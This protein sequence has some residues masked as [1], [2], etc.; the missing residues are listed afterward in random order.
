DAPA[1]TQEELDKQLIPLYW[2]R[3]P[4]TLP[5]TAGMHRWVWDLH[6][7][8]PT[9]THYEYPIS[10]VPHETPRTPQGALALPGTYMVRLK[11]NGKVL[12]TSLTLKMDP[13]VSASSAEL[14]SLFK[15]ESKL[16][17][18]VSSTAEADLVEDSVREQIEK[19]SNGASPDLKE[20]L[21]KHDKEL[22][23]L[24]SGREKL[25]GGEE[26]PGLDDVAG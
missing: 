16:S 7:A 5:A 21:E 12:T 3:M 1:S 11:A 23:A 2:L 19:L 24:L 15:A 17:G 9:A 4:H 25:T 18:M 14:E 20:L 10:A 22:S 26:E 8:T 6:Y 13:R